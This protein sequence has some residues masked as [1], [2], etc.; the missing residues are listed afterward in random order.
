MAINRRNEDGASSRGS[1]SDARAHAGQSANRSRLTL[2]SGERR[3]CCDNEFVAILLTAQ[4][5][6][7]AVNST[8]IVSLAHRRS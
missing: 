5:C 3:G 4:V 6:A 2:T 1:G 8:G 7:V